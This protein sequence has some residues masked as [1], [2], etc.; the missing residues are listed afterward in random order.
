MS[1][2][3]FLIAL[4]GILF[5]RVA[6]GCY[7]PEVVRS[8][9][10]GLLDEGGKE[11]YSF[12]ASKLA[13]N[14]SQF[15]KSIIIDRRSEQYFGIIL[16][17]VVIAVS[18]GLDIFPAICRVLSLSELTQQVPESL[19]RPYLLLSEVVRLVGAGQ[20]LAAVLRDAAERQSSELVATALYHLAVAHTSGGELTRPLQE[21]SDAF[22]EQLQERQEEKLQRLPVLATIPLLLIFAGMIV[23]TLGVPLI[24]IMDSTKQNAV[25]AR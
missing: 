10:K 20:P 4:I 21:L 14:S 22:Q 24:R 15:A 2:K 5:F 7:R 8:R 17:Q 23:L 12:R 9:V 13:Q 1:L 18:A 6:R 3:L 25:E 19:R 16:E 11:M